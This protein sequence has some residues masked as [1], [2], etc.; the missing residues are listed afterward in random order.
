M[1]DYS[2]YAEMKKTSRHELKCYVD[3]WSGPVSAS[4]I[5][6]NKPCAYL[7]LAPVSGLIKVGSTTSPIK[8]QYQLRVGN[9]SDY[10]P[11]D[12]IRGHYLYLEPLADRVLARR[13]ETIAHRVLAP[14][15]LWTGKSAESAS[16]RAKVE[17]YRVNESVATRVLQLCAE[18]VE[19]RDKLSIY[20]I[21]AKSGV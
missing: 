12:S 9:Q 20:Q 5:R 14:M 19:R 6:E 16:H 1:T 13:T 8:R 17:W 2:S 11:E 4:G 18:A 21:R 15:R 3:S 7:F 10:A